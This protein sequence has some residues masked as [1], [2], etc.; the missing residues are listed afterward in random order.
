MCTQSMVQYLE[1]M[2]YHCEDNIPGFSDAE[3]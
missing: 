2:K 3:Q 1:Y